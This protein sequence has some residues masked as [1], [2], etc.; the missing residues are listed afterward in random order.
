MT[1]PDAELDTY[2]YGTSEGARGGGRR[3]HACDDSLGAEDDL[4]ASEDEEAEE[5]YELEDDSDT[6]ERT[7]N[8]M[9]NTWHYVRRAR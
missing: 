1:E 7:K 6:L 3:V 2:T 5:P 4:G 9:S 8:M